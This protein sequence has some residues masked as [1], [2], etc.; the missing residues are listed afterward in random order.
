MIDFIQQYLLSIVAASIICGIINSLTNS[1]TPAGSVVKLLS[2]V[3]IIICV[4]SP[5]INVDFPSVT[6]YFEQFSHEAKDVAQAGFF[7]TETSIRQSIKEQSEAYIL[8]KA[9][10]MN[11]DLSVE[12]TLSDDELPVPTGV[13]LTGHVSP[14]TKSRLS[15]VID[16]DLGIPKENQ[17]WTQ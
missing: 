10:L 15:Q 13:V 2:G 3:F 8:D 5:I 7:E 16:K 1:K 9:V 11:A 12:V 4:V 17:I 14:Y 6:E